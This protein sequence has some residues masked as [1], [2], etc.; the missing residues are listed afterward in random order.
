MRLQVRRVTAVTIPPW[1]MSRW[2]QPAPSWWPL[3]WTLLLLKQPLLAITLS[4][5]YLDL[6]VC[7]V[8]NRGD[9]L[10]S[11]P[12]YQAR[13]CESQSVKKWEA[14]KIL[15]GKEIGREVEKKN[16]IMLLKLKVEPQVRESSWPLPLQVSYCEV[17]RQ[18]GQLWPLLV[19]DKEMVALHPSAQIQPKAVVSSFIVKKSLSCCSSID[20]WGTSYITFIRVARLAY[21]QHH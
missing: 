19:A 7:W 5:S 10:L 12:G 14:R 11:P 8:G 1:P 6:L 9:Q 3:N 18:I 2:W 15:L 20:A 17:N 4:S 21:W 13:I 16:W